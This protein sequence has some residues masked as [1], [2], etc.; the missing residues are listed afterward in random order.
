LNAAPLINS[1]IG[2]PLSFDIDFRGDVATW[3]LDYEFQSL[4]VMAGRPP[5]NTQAAWVF[6]GRRDK[7]G[8]DGI[9]SLGDYL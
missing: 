6:I 7:P 3:L 8:D 1:I 4:I 5:M 9:V 2:S